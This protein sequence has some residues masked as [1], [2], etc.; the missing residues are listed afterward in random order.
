MTIDPATAG[1]STP[2][3][4]QP[5]SAPAN[6][7]RKD[8]FLQLLVTSLRYQD[9]SE[10]LSTSELMAQTTQLATMEQLT[11]L[12]RL[13]QDAFV[14]Q[15][16]TSA[17]A[18]VGTEVTYLDTDGLPVSGVVSAVDFA[19]TPPGAVVDGVVVP[20]TDLTTVRSPAA[21]SAEQH[22]TDDDAASAVD[23]HQTTTD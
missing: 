13:S 20:M 8:N 7:L 10:P 6:A 19:T 2:A 12:T 3:L 17:A 11:E 9:P 5:A 22:P 21:P 1:Y 4:T 16:R 18:L 15:M 23:P 14:L